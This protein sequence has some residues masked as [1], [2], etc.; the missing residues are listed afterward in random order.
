MA[1]SYLMKR[2]QWVKLFIW[3]IHQNFPLAP[4]W[5]NPLQ[6]QW[7]WGPSMSKPFDVNLGLSQFPAVA[8]EAS[9]HSTRELHVASSKTGTW[10]VARTMA[11]WDFSY[12]SHCWHWV[13]P[14]LKSACSRPWDGSDMCGGSGLLC[15]D[16]DQLSPTHRRKY[17]TNLTSLAK[18]N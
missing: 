3:L 11:E 6:V 7:I 9:P 5:V 10:Q 15:Q 2:I 14:L 4:V 1:I 16:H 12:P 13:L 18:P 8:T 17:K